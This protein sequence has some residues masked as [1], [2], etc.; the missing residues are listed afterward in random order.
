[1]SGRTRGLPISTCVVAALA[2]VRAP[3]VLANAAPHH[4]QVGRPLGRLEP[5][6]RLPPHERLIEIRL[7]AQRRMSVL[8]HHAV[9]DTVDRQSPADDVFD[10]GRRVIHLDHPMQADSVI[11]PMHRQ[12]LD[13]DSRGTSQ[14]ATNLRFHLMRWA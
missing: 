10:I 4:L 11:D 13:V 7:R 9:D 5:M 14:R 12:R 3:R 2:R 8:D 1:M 6:A